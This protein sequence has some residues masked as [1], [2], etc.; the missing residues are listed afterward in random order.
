[1]AG[2][3]EIP[4][5]DSEDARVIMAATE[6][7]VVPCGSCHACCHSPV[8]VQ[9]QFG[10]DPDLYELAISVDSS[11][12]NRHTMITLNRKPDGSCYA[13]KNGRCS[14][15]D[16]R[17]MICRGFDCR[18]LF[19]MHTKEERRTLVAL[20]YFKQAIFD[21]GKKRLPTLAGAEELRLACKQIG[22]GRKALAYMEMRRGVK[23]VG[24]LP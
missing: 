9:P 15:W 11:A 2:G 10:D 14:I 17:P 12:P 22:Y 1:M 4:L 3:I 21:A 13:L 6:E 18:K 5:M 20:K 23:P 7:S 16:K 8:E 24:P 19:V